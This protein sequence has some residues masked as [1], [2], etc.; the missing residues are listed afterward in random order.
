MV[1]YTNLRDIGKSRV[2]FKMMIDNKYQIKVN[3]V[4]N[5]ILYGLCVCLV[6]LFIIL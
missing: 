6:A 4:R 3:K 1:E 5:S 2:S